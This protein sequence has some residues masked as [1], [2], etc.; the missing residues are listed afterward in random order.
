MNSHLIALQK[1]AEKACKEYPTE[2]NA[3]KLFAY[4]NVLFLVEPEVPSLREELEA[5]RD[6]LYS[7][8]SETTTDNE[9]QSLY[10]HTILLGFKHHGLQIPFSAEV[11]HSLVSLVETALK[12]M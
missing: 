5:F 11:Y 4:Q 8:E 10:N 1:S 3:G 9:L 12:E 7:L 2:F 6:Y